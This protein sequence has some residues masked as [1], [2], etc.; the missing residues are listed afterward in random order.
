MGPKTKRNLR[1]VTLC[2]DGASFKSVGDKY[3]ITRQ[4]VAAIFRAHGHYSP[5]PFYSARTPAFIE[6]ALDLWNT[7]LS[8]RLVADQMGVTKGVLAGV[9]Y[10]N[11]FPVRRPSPIKR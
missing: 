5:H 4:R 11:D 10:R 9:A 1:I 7:G 6:K 8:L 2:V 3:G